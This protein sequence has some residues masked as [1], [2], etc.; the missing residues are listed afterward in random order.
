MQAIHDFRHWP[1]A[2]GPPAPTPP[3]RVLVKIGELVEKFPM[4]MD[5]PF[6]PNPEPGAVKRTKKLARGRWQL[7]CLIEE[8]VSDAA[9][10]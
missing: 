6:L 3:L 4:A 1:F 9:Y 2:A 8:F 7:E 5:T 10:K